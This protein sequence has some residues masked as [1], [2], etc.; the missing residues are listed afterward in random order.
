M[1]RQFRTALPDGGVN[2]LSGLQDAQTVGRIS[3][4]PTG[5]NFLHFT[6]VLFL[7]TY[8]THAHVVDTI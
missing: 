1:T 7:I 5:R 8:S 2:A 3:V 4:A 6:N